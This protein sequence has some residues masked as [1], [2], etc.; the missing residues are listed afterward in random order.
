MC[1][2]KVTL[3]GA[4]WFMFVCR[5]ARYWDIIAIPHDPIAASA[6]LITIR[7]G[8]TAIVAGLPMKPIQDGQIYAHPLYLSPEID[9]SHVEW[10]IFFFNESIGSGGLENGN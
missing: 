1:G 2:V 10:Q 7:N 3:H 6:P 4:Y 8:N 5:H 9:P